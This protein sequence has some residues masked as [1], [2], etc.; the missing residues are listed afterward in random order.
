MFDLGKM[1]SGEG[2][3]GLGGMFGGSIMNMVKGQLASPKNIKMLSGKV[4][5]MAD[6]LCQK[7]NEESVNER[8]S[9]KAAATQRKSEIEAEY[10]AKSEEDK[11][12][13]RESTQLMINEVFKEANQKLNEIIITKYD[14]TL[15]SK[16]KPISA[17]NEKGELM[18]VAAPNNSGTM[19]ELKEDVVFIEIHAKGIIKQELRLDEFLLNMM[20]EVSGEG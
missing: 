17:K 9:I 12:A 16:L 1:L 19:V 6:M 13:S 5:D 10:N 14:I 7:F 2:G 15:V 11:A 8:E 20:V 3:G 18:L 4:V